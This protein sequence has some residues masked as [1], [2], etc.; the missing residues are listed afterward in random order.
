MAGSFASVAPGAGIRSIPNQ[1]IRNVNDAANNMQPLQPQ[2]VMPPS[3][4]GS[5]QTSALLGALLA[6]R[7]QRMQPNA[8]QPM[9]QPDQ[10]PAPSAIQTL[11]QAQAQA[12]QQ[13][14]QQQQQVQQPIQ[15]ASNPAMLSGTVP[16]IPAASPAAS[17]PTADTMRLFGNTQSAQQQL[18]NS[19]RNGDDTVAH[20]QTGELNIP[21]NVQS[22]QLMQLLQ[23][24]FAQQGLDMR[25]FI[26]GSPQGAQNPNTGLQEFA[27]I[28][29]GSNLLG[30][31]AFGQQQIVPAATQTADL[32]APTTIGGGGGYSGDGN[33][34]V[35]AIMGSGAGAMMNAGGGGV[36]SNAQ[37]SLKLGK[38]IGG[39]VSNIAN[40]IQGFGGGAAQR[41]ATAAV[42]AD[43]INRP[44][45]VMPVSQQTL[46]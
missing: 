42:Q 34:G 23:A 7:G 19:G 13:A 41:A 17:G 40:A 37:D 36:L 44:V 16:S 14:A 27:G 3:A 31:N 21:V 26:V 45:A 32:S 30:T 8:Q 10:Q 20:M 39:S 46:P 9:P 12:Q 4:Q 29:A 2:P 18:A 22:P 38:D 25:Q 15:L 24:V 5:A 33:M 28:A 35:G 11:M 1:N 43:T 6:S